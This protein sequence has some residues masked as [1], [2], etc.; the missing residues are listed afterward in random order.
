M[1]HPP[2]KKIKQ[3]SQSRHR[4]VHVLK[5]RGYVFEEWILSPT[6]FGVPNNRP[7]YYLIAKRPS[8]PSEDLFLS[9]DSSSSLA[10]TET[11][12]TSLH[13]LVL[14]RDWP[15]S[16]EPLPVSA[17]LDNPPSKDDPSI[18]SQRVEDL[19]IPPAFFKS[20][21]FLAP[22]SIVHPSALSTSCFTKAY[23]HH[24]LRAGGFLQT[25]KLDHFLENIPEELLN[26][27][28]RAQA[29]LGLRMF[30]P[31]E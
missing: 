14:K 4:L 11:E 18:E 13:P 15:E 21:T 3:T 9:S 31:Q 19:R 24:G 20:R 16:F 8:P 26:D 22:H 27:P 23:G 1:T 5:K 2:L 6:Q 25:Q 10:E 7:R 29:E 12:P 28:E 17:F 30:S